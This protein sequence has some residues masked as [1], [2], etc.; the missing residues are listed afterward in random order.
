M[1]SAPEIV[2]AAAVAFSPFSVLPSMTC[3]SSRDLTVSAET[4]AMLVIASFGSAV[5]S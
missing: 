1:Y 2:I 3:S 4:A 5:R